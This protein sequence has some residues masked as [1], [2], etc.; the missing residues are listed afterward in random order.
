MEQYLIFSALSNNNAWY[1]IQILTINDSGLT[2][3]KK[4]VFIFISL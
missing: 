4:T 2:N 3:K 1:E